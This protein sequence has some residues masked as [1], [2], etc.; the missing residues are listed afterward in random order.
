MQPTWI[1]I[2]K[3]LKRIGQ[4]KVILVDGH[5]D[6]E[7]GQDFSDPENMNGTLTKKKV[8]I[9]WLESFKSW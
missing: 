7:E 4:M 2:G 1:S 6:F 5:L 9:L 3:A 8:H